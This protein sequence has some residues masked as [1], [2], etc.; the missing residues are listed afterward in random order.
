MKAGRSRRRR[1]WAL[2][3]LVPPEAGNFLGDWNVR[4]KV[5]FIKRGR[6]LWSLIENYQSSHC[7]LL[8]QS[9]ARQISSGGCSIPFYSFVILS[10]AKDLLF[11]ER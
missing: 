9:R 8:F 5:M 6:I 1:N 11:R 3:N 4:A 2:A 10:G 7:L